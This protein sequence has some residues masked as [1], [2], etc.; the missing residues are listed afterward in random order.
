MSLKRLTLLGMMGVGA[1][2]SNMPDNCKGIRE[3]DRTCDPRKAVDALN[4]DGSGTHATYGAIADWKMAEVT[5]MSFLFKGASKRTINAD[6]S[7]W[8]VSA[9]TTTEAMFEDANAFNSDLSKWKT[10]KV[11]NMFEMFH[12]AYKFNSD[13]SE[14]ETGQVTT[15]S[16][17][18]YNAHIFNSP[19]NTWDTSQV[20]DMS[21]MFRQAYAFDQDV[22]YL[23]TSQVE[24]I[25]NMFELALAFNQP[26][27]NFGPFDGSITDSKLKIFVASPCDYCSRTIAGTWT[28]GY[29]H[30]P[31]IK[32]MTYL[33]G[34][35]SCEQEPS[36]VTNGV[37]TWASKGDN[38]PD[39]AAAP[40]VM[41]KDPGTTGYTMTNTDL[42]KDNFDVTG[43]CADDYG[44]SV[45][46]EAC[47]EAGEYTVSGCAPLC[48][49]VTCNSTD[50]GKNT[51][52]P[53]IYTGDAD[54]CC[55]PAWVVRCLNGT[56]ADLT[57]T[58]PGCV[59]DPSSYSDSVQL[60]DRWRELNT[61]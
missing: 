16:Q 7:K 57:L 33:K 21:Q 37:V 51:K 9:V 52:I 28:T 56:K 4:A 54:T 15:M 8:D 29:Y 60:R 12:G 14:W 58:E 44:G 40:P 46:A 31:T 1:A 61:C 39:R 49:G 23:D 34:T 59:G 53:N 17:M 47:T 35:K 24:D 6:L 13:V 27:D 43:V 22:S 19:I 11:T 50:T 41:C 5:D 36:S 32:T 2:S 25:S 30:M 3:S 42:D 45:T 55:G 10:G 48:T 18:F 38:C 20:T 26:L